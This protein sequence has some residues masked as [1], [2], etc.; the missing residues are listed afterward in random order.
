M[1][2]IS[3]IV[4]KCIR[5][6][7][8]LTSI[9]LVKSENSPL[10]HQIDIIK[11][12]INIYELCIY[13]LCNELTLQLMDPI[14]SFLQHLMKAYHQTLLILI[15]PMFQSLITSL[16]A[17]VIYKRPD[18]NI[19][20]HK[21][22]AKMI[23]N[24]LE[25][26]QF[27][28]LNKQIQ[29]LREDIRKKERL[30]IEMQKEIE[31]NHM[32][33]SRLH[34]LCIREIKMHVTQ[35]AYDAH[36]QRGQPQILKGD[37]NEAQ[38]KGGKKEEKIAVYDDG[39]VGI[40]AF[41]RD[42]E[43]VVDKEMK[44]FE[45]NLAKAVKDDFIK[46]K[47]VFLQKTK[48]LTR[49]KTRFLNKSMTISI[50]NDDMMDDVDDMAE[51]EPIEL[52]PQNKEFISLISEALAG[53]D[54]AL[55]AKEAGVAWEL[56]RILQ[57]IL[58]KRHE[59][60]LRDSQVKQ[61]M[62]YQHNSSSI[63][64]SSS[65]FS[66]FNIR[67]R[68]SSMEKKKKPKKTKKTEK[69]ATFIIEKKDIALDPIIE[70][71]DMKEFDGMS[72]EITLLKENLNNLYQESKVLNRTIDLKNKD[73]KELKNDILAEKTKIMTEISKNGPL[74]MQIIEIEQENDRLKSLIVPLE[75]KLAKKKEKIVFLKKQMLTLAGTPMHARDN[76]AKLKSQNEEYF[77]EIKELK[78][79]IENYKLIFKHGGSN[80]K[81]EE[82]IIDAKPLNELDIL[83]KTNNMLKERL[84]RVEKSLRD[85]ENH[86]FSQEMLIENMVNRNSELL[87]KIKNIKGEDIKSNIITEYENIMKNVEN[88]L[89]KKIRKTIK[90]NRIKGKSIGK[91]PVSMPSQDRESIE[92]NEENTKLFQDNFEKENADYHE[93]SGDFIE[94]IGDFTENP[95]NFKENVEKYEK[96][97]NLQ[98][99]SKYDKTDKN[100][101]SL[102]ISKNS[103]NSKNEKKVKNAKNSSKIEKYENNHE[104]L[105]KSI[106]KPIKYPSKTRK[107]I[108]IHTYIPSKS[109]YKSEKIEET[110]SYPAEYLTGLQEKLSNLRS[111]LTV[112]KNS[113]KMPSKIDFSVAK[114]VKT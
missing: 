5:L 3:S 67:N 97:E 106:E 109:T 26:S 80:T 25:R 30:I 72:T 92:R 87:S 69:I 86:G 36:I 89:G 99:Q 15:K 70:V 41:M 78:A 56:N 95:E 42:I 28:G 59:Y 112:L 24:A 53:K 44:A 8:R 101:K 43:K 2:K 23:E 17:G 90:D 20:L 102:Q 66:S 79:I 51:I 88:S 34:D 63:P 73:I 111:N 76:I 7:E 96:L 50:G 13:E 40:E 37:N 114:F 93:N 9:L 45:T 49:Q 32:V 94:K 52:S 47:P 58:N 81:E 104:N 12:N 61:L 18:E 71:F 108:S 84:Y 14:S 68:F 65:S 62:N 85:S 38:K 11:S 29:G 39:K 57:G 64:R 105:D 16:P 75:E 6:M 10:S 74:K 60:Q 48:A 1:E 31:Q 77:N 46:K 103:K 4:S 91:K 19:G 83:K 110:S 113:S 27:E 35:K 98:K 107:S 100:I 21:E 22:N 55:E 33:Q 82:A 54:K